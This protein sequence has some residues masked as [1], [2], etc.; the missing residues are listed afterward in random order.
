MKYLNFIIVTLVFGFCL[1]SFGQPNHKSLYENNV[2][3]DSIIKTYSN[4]KFNFL[5]KGDTL[6]AIEAT[7]TVANEHSTN[8]SY[9]KAY[10]GYW[11]A[12][13]Y[14]NSVSDST[15]M[16]KIYRKL[17]MLYSV[18][19]RIEKAESYFEL[20]LK[21]IRNFKTRESKMYN[22]LNNTFYLMA[23]HN[24]ENGNYG[25][26]LRYLDSCEVLRKKHLNL[27][28]LNF[29]NAERAYIAYH[30]GYY[31]KALALL[32]NKENYFL[33][34][35]PGYLVIY[36]SFL[37]DIYFKK[38]DFKK[39]EACYMNALY[40]T[41]KYKSHRNYVP[42]VYH[43]LSEL[44]RKTGKMQL[45]YENLNKS[46]ELSD[47]LFGARSKNNSEILEIKDNYRLQTDKQ[48]KIIEQARL[49]NLEHEQKNLF[50]K[51]LLL[52]LSIITLT[53][54]TG[55]IYW[56][57]SKKRK[58]EKLEFLT[59]QKL[60]EEK[61]TEILEIKNKELTTSALQLIQKDALITDIRKSLTQ[62]KELNK[63]EINK[64]LTGIKINK[65]TDWK[66]FN[67]R[68]NSVNKNFYKILSEN[69]PG[70]TLSD[71]RM[72]ALIKLNFSSKEIAS[73]LGISMESVNTARYR[74]RKKLNLHK[75]E[76]LPEF[77]SKI[78]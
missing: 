70:L 49:K 66:V 52:T 40:S 57:L 32:K 5:I 64:I 28:D 26:A 69:H 38:N 37:G 45:A 60:S 50:L 67:A 31:D 48:K 11:E 68:F 56:T 7:I 24:R 9:S 39:S 17:G 53:I 41:E 1:V 61:N 75:N 13:I 30:Q 76:D 4:K 14:S 71:K 36:Y 59:K 63:S 22:D 42:N 47:L 20:S 44:F 21:V 10:D 73:L 55:F 19:R 34:K 18:F 78:S 65:N 72:C 23:S 33:K 3:S 2:N 6:K 8:G 51:N 35:S 29:I 54:I 15:Y 27:K 58:L 77:I 43:K 74:L 12:L 46:K 62:K 25:L 16:G